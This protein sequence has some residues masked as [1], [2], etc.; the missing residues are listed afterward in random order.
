MSQA[1]AE[2]IISHLQGQQYIQESYSAFLKRLKKRL[3]LFTGN[4]AIAFFSDIQIAQLLLDLNILDNGEKK[5]L[6]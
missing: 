4:E 1:R 6:Q 2:L 5:C 3:R